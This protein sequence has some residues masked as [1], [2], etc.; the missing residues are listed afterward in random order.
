MNARVTVE[1][2]AEDGAVVVRVEGTERITWVGD[3]TDRAFVA[4][5]RELLGADAVAS[6]EWAL[7]EKLT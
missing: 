3:P 1:R 4:M 5:V 7:N 6:I 2:R